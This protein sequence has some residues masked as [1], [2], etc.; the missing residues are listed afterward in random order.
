MNEKGFLTKNTVVST[1]MSNLGFYHALE[2]NDMKS[3]Q[4]AV[5]DRYVMEVMREGGY[6]LGGEQSG[7]IIFLDYATSGDG[8][9]SALQLVNV[10]KDTGKKLSELASEI[11]ILPQVL[12]NVRVEDKEQAMHHVDVKAAIASVEEALGDDGRVLVRPSGTEPLVRVMVE[13]QTEEDCEKFVDQIVAV[14]TDTC[15]IEE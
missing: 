4:A 11:T 13:A 8:M 5:G 6:N 14:I 7:H 3:E 15:G 1:V 12:K 10:M 2:A 9:L